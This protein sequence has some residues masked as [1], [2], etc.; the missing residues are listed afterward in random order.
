VVLRGAGQGDRVS[1]LTCSVVELLGHDIPVLLSPTP[2]SNGIEANQQG[3]YLFCFSVIKLVC[4]RP[5]VGNNTL[6]KGPH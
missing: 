1:A 6:M 5:S 4:F 2:V 3:L